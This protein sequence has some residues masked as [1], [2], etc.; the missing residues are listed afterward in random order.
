GRTV[1]PGGL[2]DVVV[3]NPPYLGQLARPDGGRVALVLPQSVLA[4]RDTAAIRRAVTDVA[5]VTGFWWTSARVFPA[6]VNVGILVL[7]RGVA[8][9]SV[10]RWEGRA[11]S[12]RADVPADA[13]LGPTWAPLIADLAGLPPVGLTAT[14]GRLADL[15]SATAGFRQHFYGLVPFVG[16]GGD[17]PPLVTSGLIDAGTCAWGARPARFA[18]RTFAAPRVDLDALD[19]ADA[20]LAA[21]VRQQLAPKVLVA[22]QTRVIEAV[23]DPHGVWV[24]SVPV[25]AVHPRRVEDLWAVGAVLL[26]PPVA[27]WAAQRYLGAGLGPTTLKLSAPQLLELPLPL[28]GRPWDDA[29]RC[30]RTGDVDGCAV[31]MGAAYGLDPLIY[32]PLLAWWRDAAEP[33]GR[34][35][36]VPRRPEG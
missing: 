14:Q 8:Q 5:A 33:A 7:Q 20:K 17:G 22:A 18:K 23:V 32:G 3:G 9:E 24:P 31:L 4:T 12:R 19:R 16:D 2:F 27:A 36:T 15:A 11:F 21:W 28:P 1:D 29:A 25:V 10:R 35:R 34:R 13:V 30:L 26:A 6:A